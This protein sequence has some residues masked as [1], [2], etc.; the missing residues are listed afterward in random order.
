MKKILSLA[1]LLAF[2]VACG[3]ESSQAKQP[4]ATGPAPAAASAGVA[5]V[6]IKKEAT[7]IE[8]VVVRAKPATDGARV[9]CTFPGQ[10]CGDQDPYCMQGKS[11]AA[12][13]DASL[14]FS[15]RTADKV[16]VGKWENYWYKI[17]QEDTGNSCEGEAWV[18]GQFVK[19][20]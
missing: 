19:L 15:A 9:R 3:K 2:S 7:V 10:V 12:P 11:S 6:A 4:A 18:F 16:K 13:T 20:K 17:Q 14:T 8:P 5:T 1:A